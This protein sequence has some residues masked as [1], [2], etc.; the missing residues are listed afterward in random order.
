MSKEGLEK[1]DSKI[2][3]KIKKELKTCNKNNKRFKAKNYKEYVDSFVGRTL[4]KMFFEKIRKNQKN[5]Q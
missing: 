4:R 5:N 2:R 1:F 3:K